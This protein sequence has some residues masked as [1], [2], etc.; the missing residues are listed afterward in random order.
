M[1]FA[2]AR[3]MFRPFRHGHGAAGEGNRVTYSKYF[4]RLK[5]T[6]VLVPTMVLEFEYTRGRGGATKHLLGWDSIVVGQND[7]FSAT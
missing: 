3:L 6:R 2:T 4:P 1:L 5:L 7:V